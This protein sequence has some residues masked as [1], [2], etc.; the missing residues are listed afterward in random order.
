MFRL[1]RII[2][3][4]FISVTLICTFYLAT[5]SNYISLYDKKIAVLVDTTEPVNLRSSKANIPFTLDSTISDSI[6]NELEGKAVMGKLANET[7]RA[8]L[9]QS[10]WYLL[11]VMASRYPVEPTETEKILVLGF[12]K[13]LSFLYPCGDCAVHFQ[14]NL[15]KLPP[16]VDSRDAFEQW[17][18]QI[19][20]IVNKSLEKPIFDCKKVHDAYDCGCGPDLIR[21]DPELDMLDH[22][23]KSIESS[24]FNRDLESS[25]A[26]S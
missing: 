23:S 16:N 9:G 3:I 2:P 10:T 4:L 6:I 8:Q 12:I 14:Q 19:H 20:N 21:Y 15:K 13:Y 1:N 17:L 18:C 5:Q 7:L 11:H 26:V 24:A 25:A 22:T